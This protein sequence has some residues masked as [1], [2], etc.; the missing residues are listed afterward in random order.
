VIETIA[1]WIIAISLVV[2][3]I[4]L[5]WLIDLTRRT[6]QVLITQMKSLGEMYEQ[7]IGG[8]TLT[9]ERVEKRVKILEDEVL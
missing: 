7:G 9:L 4:A 2:G 5:L 8:L 6:E 1:L 3:V